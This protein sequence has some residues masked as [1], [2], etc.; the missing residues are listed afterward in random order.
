M[1]SF[2][3]VFITF[4]TY[5]SQISGILIIL[6][7]MLKSFSIFIKDLISGKTSFAAFRKS[8]LELGHAFSLGLGFLIGASI[9]RS[10]LAPN[11]DD[12]GKLASIIMIRTALNYF[13]LR[14]VI[15]L[16]QLTEIN[17]QASN[18]KKPE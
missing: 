8:R 1:E 11:W 10:T 14:D 6:L 5:I 13:L 18:Q 9:I 15:S 2:M 3:R 12:I 17:P 7:G 16:N 4:V